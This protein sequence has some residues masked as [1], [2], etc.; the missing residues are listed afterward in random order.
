MLDFFGF[1][2]QD[3][4][5]EEVGMRWRV[6]LDRDDCTYPQLELAR[7]PQVPVTRHRGASGPRLGGHH[8]R[9]TT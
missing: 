4:V 9:G 1:E 8:R 5:K 6:G 7:L 2:L 3:L